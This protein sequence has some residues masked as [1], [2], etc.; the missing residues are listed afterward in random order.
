MMILFD[1]TRPAKSRRSIRLFGIGLSRTRPERP[2]PYSAADLAWWS[3]HSP[4]NATGYEVIGRSTAERLEAEN[5]RLEQA[6]GCALA[7]AR[8]DAGFG[9]F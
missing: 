6:A 2:A 5:R 7:Q 4:A 3:V 1:A 9:P 8:M